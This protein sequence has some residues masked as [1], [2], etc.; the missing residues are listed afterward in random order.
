MNCNFDKIAKLCSI[1][2][3]SLGTLALKIGRSRQYLYQVRSGTVKPKIGDMQRIAAV[4]GTTVEYLSDETDDPTPRATDLFSADKPI[5][6]EDKAFMSMMDIANMVATRP[7]ANVLFS[8]LKTATD[9]DIKR[10]VAIL[11]AVK[12]EFDE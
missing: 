9:E 5:T 6:S 2:R 7:Q 10:V 11:K 1:R 12:G 3:V 4:L 8:V